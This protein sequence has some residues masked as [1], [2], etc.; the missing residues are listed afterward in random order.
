MSAL[1]KLTKQWP[2]I[3]GARK[4]VKIGP[5]LFKCPLCNTIVYAGKRS[6]D[7]IKITYPE[8]I[9]G[10][11]DVDHIKPVI[12]IEDSGKD[13][14]WNTIIN[15]LFCDEDNVQCICSTCHKEKSNLERIGRSKARKINSKK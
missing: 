5:E 6:I 3:I 7:S 12:P 8:A 2:P 1:R 10:R 4:K 9:S 14:D 15:N 11:M 13:K